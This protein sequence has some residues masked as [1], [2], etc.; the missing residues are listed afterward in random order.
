MATR[1]EAFPSKYLR[2]ADLKGKPITVTIESATL[3]TLKSPDGKEQTKTVLRFVGKTKELPLNRTNWDQ[4]AS[5][6]GED[7]SDNWPSHKIELYPTTTAMRGHMT[8]C[9]RVRPP[10]QRELPK[11]SKPLPPKPVAKPLEEEIDDEVPF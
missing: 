4:V 8:D 11:S 6:T 2:C 3:E 7:D 5:I 1:D 9:V 10:A